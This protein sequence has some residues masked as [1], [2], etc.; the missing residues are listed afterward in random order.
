M[1]LSGGLFMDFFG[2]GERDGLVVV[3]VRGLFTLS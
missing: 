3:V 2:V 1:H